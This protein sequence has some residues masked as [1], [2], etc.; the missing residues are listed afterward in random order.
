MNDELN[1]VEWLRRLANKL[2]GQV[3]GLPDDISEQGGLHLT[4]TVMR[5][6][7]VQ[8][9][10]REAW[11]TLQLVYDEALDRDRTLDEYGT[12]SGSPDCGNGVVAD[13]LCAAAAG[14]RKRGSAVVAGGNS[15]TDVA[16]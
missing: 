5:L 6:D 13:I 15:A 7:A 16:S 8:N 1:D 9:T 3:D 2:V 4:A 11:N 10:L 14:L 12:V